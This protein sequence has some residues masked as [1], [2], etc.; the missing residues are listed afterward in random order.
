M[1]DVKAPSEATI[2]FEYEIRTVFFTESILSLIRI[3]VLVYVIS[4]T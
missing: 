4:E 2:R 3:Y 1:K